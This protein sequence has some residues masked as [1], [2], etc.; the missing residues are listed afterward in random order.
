[1]SMQNLNTA[2]NKEPLKEEDRQNWKS[3]IPSKHLLRMHVQAMSH[4]WKV[5]LLPH[6]GVSCRYQFLLSIFSDSNGHCTNMST[7]SFHFSL[8]LVLLIGRYMN[9]MYLQCAIAKRRAY[10]LCCAAQTCQH[11]NYS[12]DARRDKV[13]RGKQQ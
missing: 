10:M 4:Q 7:C 6:D 8:T 3:S 13:K 2:H 9:V 11:L 1:M 5:G 12:S